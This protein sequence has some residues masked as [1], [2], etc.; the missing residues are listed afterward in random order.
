[1][2]NKGA[3][4]YKK[5]RPGSFLLTVLIQCLL[6]KFI[7]FRVILFSVILCHVH[8]QIDIPKGNS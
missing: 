7:I 3:V 8:L 2:A 1:M 5:S 4:L 6:I